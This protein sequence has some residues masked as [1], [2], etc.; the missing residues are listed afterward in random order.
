MAVERAKQ[1]LVESGNYQPH[2]H[3]KRC[4]NAL[5]DTLVKDEETIIEV[6]QSLLRDLAP[7]KIV[8]TN[9][10][11]IIAMPSFWGLYFGFNL[12]SPSEISI[13][14]Y[15]NIISV[16]KTRGRLFSSVHIRIH[17][18][19]D[20]SQAVKKEGEVDGLWPADALK[21]STFITEVVENMAL[22]GSREEVFGK[23]EGSSRQTTVYQEKRSASE[24][25]L[26]EAFDKV[27]KGAKFIWLG[28]EPVQ[29]VVNLLGVDKEKVIKVSLGEMTDLK[30]EKVAAWKGCILISYEESEA[31]H[32]AKILKRDYGV[33]VFVMRGGIE[34]LS[35]K[36][37]E[38]PF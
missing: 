16:L 37:G 4:L 21:I 7:N 25:T 31:L 28:L 6:K 8:V 9:K 20:S 26:K 13:I 23:V 30:R 19:A 38:E 36:F 33:D 22:A 14:P 32:L 1:T 11:V 18:F 12:G 17:G 27:E 5:K 3:T 29:E 35:R 2:A 10:R 15:N 24:L 34:A